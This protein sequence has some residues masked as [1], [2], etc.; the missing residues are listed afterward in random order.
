MPTRNVFL[1]D[2]KVAGYQALLSELPADSEWF[3]IDSER[4]GIEQIAAILSR[5]QNLDAIQ[6]ISHGSPGTLYLGAT[7]LDATNL[8]QYS[9]QLANIGAALTESGD[10]LLYG[11]NV[12]ANEAG[13]LFVADLAAITGA[14]VAASTNISGSSQLLADNLLEMQSG[15]I[16][17]GVIKLESLRT[18]LTVNTAPSFL[19]RNG[20]V[21][22]D[23][24]T[25]QD[26]ACSVIPQVDGKI[27]VVGDIYYL[28]SF[29][30]VRCKT[31]GDLDQTFGSDGIVITNVGTGEYA[32]GATVQADGRFVV[33]GDLDGPNYS[34]NFAVLRYEVNGNLD[35]TFG[36]GGIANTD[37]GKKNSDT[38]HSAVIQADGKIVAAGS[39][40]SKNSPGA[41]LDFAIVRYNLDGSLDE[42]FGV[43]GIVS[44]N[45]GS[46][47][48][49]A[50][51]VTVQQ[52]GKLLVAGSSGHYNFA[53]ARYSADGQLDTAFGLGGKV[54]TKVGFGLA[55]TVVV[56]SDGKILVAG[57][58]DVSRPY[59]Y[60]TLT[61]TNF[62]IV[63]YN[64]DGSLDGSFGSG[65]I[66]TTLRGTVQGLD[67]M[68]KSTSTAHSMVVQPDGKILLAGESAAYAIGEGAEFTVMRYNANGSL[69]T[70][71]GVNGIVTTDVGTGSS[72][73]YSVRL[74]QDGKI[75]VAGQAYDSVTGRDFALA[76]YNVDGSLDS[77]FGKANIG[78]LNG[79]VLYVEN[80]KPVVLDAGVQVTD[81]ELNLTNFNGS[82]LTLA[83]HDGA[84]VEDVFTGSGIVSALIEGADFT[85]SDTVIGTVTKN[86]SGTLVLAFNA[87]ATQSLVNSAMQGIAYSNSSEAPPTT[88]QIDWTFSDGNTGAQGDGGVYSVT[89]NTTV[90]IAA[91]ND[92]PT[93]RVTIIGGASPGQLLSVSN[94]LADLDGM[95]EV[96]YLWK[97]DGTTIGSGATYTLSSAES[98]KSITVVA[99]YMDAKGTIES[100]ESVVPKHVFGD[101]NGTD[102]DDS[103][104]AQ[105]G[106]YRLF[107]GKG[108]DVLTT[109]ID[110]KGSLLKGGEGDDTL[111]AGS[112]SDV[113]EFTGS[114][115]QY[116]VRVVD[117]AVMVADQRTGSANDGSDQLQGVNLLK[118]ADGTEFLLAASQRFALTGEEVNHLIAVNES[119]LYNGTKAAETF[120][121]APETSA[122]ILAGAGDVV[123][124]AGAFTDYTYASRGSQLQIFDDLFMTTVNIGGAITIKTS[125][126]SASALLS[127]AQGVPTI[128]LNGHAVGAP[129]FDAHTI[130][131]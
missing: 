56:Q 99:S 105:P 121:V 38:S 36:V 3:L 112:R 2:A 24:G 29:C 23:L 72:A 12:A 57:Y 41:D 131:G 8:N 79:K 92:L 89:G 18:A 25:D 119:K 130:L 125:E 44:T 93:G 118:F 20:M 61:D 62:V 94:T 66:V 96:S 122:M 78:D 86:S 88:V 84:N 37:I 117:G 11:C 100:L 63:R 27:L 14:D 55:E 77:T 15:S 126:G 108:H 46:D 32:H 58:A 109:S 67:P 87:N 102:N 75:L 6:I 35:D 124:L 45:M 4:D 65:G 68:Y 40:F 16:Q 71:F 90:A 49:D 42:S 76:R 21:T 106:A 33:I 39:S 28:E 97:A 129:G 17:E 13:K 59:R 64:S 22:I 115:D 113:A 123:E 73:G 43:G 47:W 95:G 103:L 107:G 5:Y 19:I 26:Q 80:A 31:N 128:S 120:A 101:V 74:Q 51:S 104:H 110:S 60:L 50:R 30:V 127:L 52:D 10:I 111:I 69:D 1:I 7:T 34:R 91:V 70:T 81:A 98:G 83:R 9:T 114:R 53:V 48:D 54:V 85:V 82:A 116:D